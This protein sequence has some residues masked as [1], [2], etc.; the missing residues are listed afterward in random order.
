MD[1]KGKVGNPLLRISR[2]GLCSMINAK[3]SIE[4][5]GR[6]FILYVIKLGLL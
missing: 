3:P 5:K 6:D 4:R 1:F 2:V